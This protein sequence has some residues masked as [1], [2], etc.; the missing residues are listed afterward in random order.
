MDNKMLHNK[1]FIYYKNGENQIKIKRNTNINDLKKWKNEFISMN[2]MNPF[3][4]EKLLVEAFCYF[5]K[6]KK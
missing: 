6:G 1:N 4:S 2:S 5:L 3:K